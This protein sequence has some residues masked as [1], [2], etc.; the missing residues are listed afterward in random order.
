MAND[1]KDRLGVVYS[2]NPDFE[3]TNNEES[4]QETLPVNHQKLRVALDRTKLK[5]KSVTLITWFVGT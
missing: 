1:W 4:E 2:T 3:F 5:R